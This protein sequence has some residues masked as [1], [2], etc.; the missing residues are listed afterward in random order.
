MIQHPAL[1]PTAEMCWRPALRWMSESSLQFD[2][3]HQDQTTELE[4]LKEFKPS[5]KIVRFYSWL[6]IDITLVISG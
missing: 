3:T 4:T 2:K 6:S 5:P 1:T